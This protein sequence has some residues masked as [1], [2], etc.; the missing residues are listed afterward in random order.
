MQLLS[1]C[2]V[3]FSKYRHY[4]DA[5]SSQCQRD[6]LSLRMTFLNSSR[7]RLTLRKKAMFSIIKINVAFKISLLSY[8]S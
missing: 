8:P 4:F 5:N 6:M 2:A 7:R 3:V 1:N